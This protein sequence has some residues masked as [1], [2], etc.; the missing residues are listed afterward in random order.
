[1]SQELT[2]SIFSQKHWLRSPSR[3][4]L[5]KTLEFIIITDNVLSPVL[6]LL[7]S[8]SY[9]HITCIEMAWDLYVVS[10]IAGKAIQLLKTKASPDCFYKSH[11]NQN[12]WF[13]KQ[14]IQKVLY[15]CNYYSN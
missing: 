13:N 7:L 10:F 8:N 11:S 1:M 2:G 3:P 12:C 5:D 14:C 15:L 9:V 4:R 6:G